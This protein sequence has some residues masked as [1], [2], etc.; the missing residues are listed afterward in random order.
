MD[1]KKIAIVVG[2]C[3]VVAASVL[4][5]LHMLFID[6]EPFRTRNGMAIEQFEQNEYDVQEEDIVYYIGDGYHDLLDAE[7]VEQPTLIVPT[8]RGNTKGNMMNEGHVA[9]DGEWVYFICSVNRDMYRMKHDGSYLQLVLSS[10]R[11]IESI[12]L[13]KE[14]IF[15]SDG[16]DIYRMCRS[17]SEVTLLY[18]RVYSGFLPFMMFYYGWLYFI[19]VGNNEHNAI[20]RVSWDGAYREEFIVFQGSDR[21]VNRFAIAY[22]TLYYC[23]MWGHGL[24]KVCLE[25]IQRK[26][27][28]SVNAFNPSPYDG[29]IYF[30]SFYSR[31]ENYLHRVKPDG[32]NQ[33]RIFDKAVLAYNIHQG[34]IYVVASTYTAL[35]VRPDH[36]VRLYR[37]N[38][39]GSDVELLLAMQDTDF[40]FN[41]LLLT[42]EWIYL[43][44]MI[45]RAPTH[46]IRIDG[47]GLHCLS[48]LHN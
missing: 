14:W 5:A 47:T 36:D 44:P 23:L 11:R 31:Y 8:G 45:L 34:V 28:T 24:Y 19:E 9:Q 1:V 37:M 25:G 40:I 38:L 6:N 22:G 32:S 12:N 16:G 10:P 20:I 27:I 17:T 48:T 42:D 43:T 46:R 33:E 18:E 30:T 35:P 4:I 7:Y 13:T 29:W 3:V 39:D 15:Y 26:N 41:F 2:L 21:I